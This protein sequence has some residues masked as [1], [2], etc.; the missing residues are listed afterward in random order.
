MASSLQYEARVS[1]L[2][3][4][5]LSE[6]IPRVGTGNCLPM[7]VADI[8]YIRTQEAFLYLALITDRWSRKIGGYHLKET[9]ET[10]PVLKALALALQGLKGSARPIH[11]SDRGCR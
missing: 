5:S 6:S 4:P 9:L 8:T 2:N 11:H 3:A 7:R 1:L 10:E